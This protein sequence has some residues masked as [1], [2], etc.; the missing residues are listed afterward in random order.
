VLI[1]AGFNPKLIQMF[2]GHASIQTTMDR[3]G[4]LFRY[5]Y[6]KAGEKIDHT[7]FGQSNKNLTEQ[8][9]AS[10][11]FEMQDYRNSF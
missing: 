6:E 1:A 2:L 9:N 8:A 11:S 4:H 5:D 3:Y 10:K 7:I